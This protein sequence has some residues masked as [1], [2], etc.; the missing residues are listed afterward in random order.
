MGRWSKLMAPVFLKW[1]NFPYNMSWL[2]V[3]CGTGS[4]SEAIFENYKPAYL[5][6]VDPSP[7]FLEKAKEKNSFTADFLTGSASDLPLT[8]NSFDIVVSGLALNFFP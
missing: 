7:E 2:D 8:D 6:C 5:C 1:L 3:G 4:L